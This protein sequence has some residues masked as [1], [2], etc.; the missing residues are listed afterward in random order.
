MTPFPLTLLLAG[1]ACGLCNADAA[2]LFHE[3]FE[4]YAAG[5][6]LLG[7][8]GWNGTLAPVLVNDSPVFGGQGSRVLDGI[9]VGHLGS[10]Y[11]SALHAFAA[12]AQRYTLS[13]DAA[14]Y[15]T[16]NTWGG[17]SSLV[18]G[19]ATHVDTG[20]F[21]VLAVGWHFIVRD[22]GVVQTDYAL[23]WG[24][25]LLQLSITVDP[26]MG[27]VSG[28]FDG[29]GG[30]LDTPTFAVSQHFIDALDG[31]N[32]AVDYRNREPRQ[33]GLQIDNIRIDTVSAVPE[34]GTQGL[35][36]AGVAALTGWLRRGALRRV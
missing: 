26:V 6:N 19:S 18:E 30:P 7:Q 15:D 17:L 12:P 21:W 10:S 22:A 8:G 29:S 11:G 16:F 33:P 27:Q 13:F 31:M 32:F 24:G 20:A 35:L 36:L 9:T 23:P 4:S 5:S 3:D 25:N 14:A 1:A 28:H 34:S 2:T